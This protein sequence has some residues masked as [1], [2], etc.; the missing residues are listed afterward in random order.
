MSQYEIYTF[1]L[2]F[3]VF[4]ALTV[5]FSVLLGYVIRLTIRLIRVGAEDEKILREA[6]LSE[7]KKPS[8][9]LDLLVKLFNAVV[10]GALCLVF[11][12][13]L[14]LNLTEHRFS[15]GLP[16]LKVVQSAS[17]SYQHEKNSYLRTNRLNNQL[18]IFDLIVTHSLPA[19]QDL[20]LYDIVV[21][22]L[23]GEL[24]IHRI[25]G[26]EEPNE[27]HPNERYF[28]LQGDASEYKDRYPVRYSQMRAIYRDE[29]VPFIGSFIS[30]MQSPA[31]YLCILLTL[32]AVIATP[33]TEKKI[34][35]EKQLRLRAIGLG[36]TDKHGEPLKLPM[37]SLRFRCT[38][39]N[40]WTFH[41]YV[42]TNRRGRV[43]EVRKE[44]KQK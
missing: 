18:Q 29:R 21:Y 34:E 23:E 4:I 10:C 40:R 7:T 2:C 36:S 14:A 3:I 16:S 15:S 27:K 33:I 30:F 5:L 13:S 44:P 24:V 8:R 25:V 12:F 28:L 22:E 32:F 43:K 26:I 38:W 35:E 1:V 41:V 9:L 11:L 31:G 20:Q 17:M 39:M 42:A 37:R 6:R 19:E